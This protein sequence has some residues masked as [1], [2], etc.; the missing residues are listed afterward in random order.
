MTEIS[1]MRQYLHP[2]GEVVQITI[3]VPL[4]AMI[5]AHGVGPEDYVQEAVDH[6]DRE[7]FTSG[8]GVVPLLSRE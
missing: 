8:R 6:I 1:V 5:A 7:M 4:P 3:C 2:D